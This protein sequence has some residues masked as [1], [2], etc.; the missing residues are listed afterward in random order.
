MDMKPLA[1]KLINHGGVLM[2]IYDTGF[3]INELIWNLFISII[4]M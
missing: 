3:R 2:D 4:L 1:H